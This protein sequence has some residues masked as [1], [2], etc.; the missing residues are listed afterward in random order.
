[1]ITQ[2][3]FTSG[4][5][6]GRKVYARI[7]VADGAILSRNSPWPTSV[8]DEPIVGDTGETLYLPIQDEADQVVDSDLFFVQNT[9]EIQASRVLNR[10]A[11][12]RRSPDEIKERARNAEAFHRSELTPDEQLSS[13]CIEGLAAI[14][15]QLKGLTL[16]PAE[17]A[18]KEA[19]TAKAAQFAANKARLAEIETQ[20]NAGQ[21]PDLKA[22]WQKKA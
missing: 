20:I 7:R 8:D 4:P 19:I 17:N 13:L 3:R 18:M 16:S 21:D 15:K 2:R 5:N 10:K 12:V 1:M 11:A 14:Y 9:E 6:I 22:G